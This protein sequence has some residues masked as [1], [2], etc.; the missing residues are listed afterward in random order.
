MKQSDPPI[1]VS[2]FYPTKRSEVWSA[3]SSKEEMIQWYF[4]QIPFFETVVGTKIE[5]LVEN[6]G[7]SFTH[8]WTILE[9]DPPN[10]LL[11]TW[12]Y[13]EHSGEATMRFD[14][15]DTSE[16][17]E[18]TATCTVL[19]DFPQDIPEFKRESCVAGWDYFLNQA[20]AGYLK[21]RA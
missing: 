9:A 2:A 19:K 17:T 8:Q 6:E 18:V 7:R 12:S 4:P 10:C 1:I 15:T 21:K 20:L 11:H 5:F 13:Q 16:G 3:L 14:L